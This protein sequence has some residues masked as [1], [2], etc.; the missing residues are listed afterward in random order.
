MRILGIS[1][2][3]HDAA[4]ALLEDGRLVAAGMQEAYSRV[5]HDP[6]YPKDAIEFCL[7]R[8]GCRPQDLDYVVFY[9]K[10]FSKFHRLLQTL[11]GT[12]PRSWRVFPKAMQA[13]F[14]EKLW[15]RNI[16]LERLGI[17]ASRLLFVD[18]HLSHAASSF[19]CS[20]FPDAAVLTIDGVGEWATA[21]WGL[22]SS[23]PHGSRLSLE[24]E[25]RFPHSI[26]LLYS[27]FTAFLGFEVNEGEYKVMGMAAYGSPRH[28]EKVRKLVRCFPD[29]SFELNMDYFSFHYSDHATYNR[30]FERLF[31]EPRDPSARFVT[32]RTSLYDDPTPPSPA[33]LERNQEYADIA[34]SVQKVVEDLVVAMAS[35]L[36]RR[37]GRE[38]LCMA[39]GVAFNCLANRRILR[40]TGFKELFIQ[41][42]A[43]D[44]GGALG[45]ALFAHHVLL[46]QPRR[47]AMEHAFWGE[48]FSDEQA[49]AAAAAAGLAA[50]EP[51]EEGLLERAAEALSAGKVIGFYRD[52]AEWGPRALGH[53]SILASPTKPEMKD[54]VNIKIK[55]REP[56]RPFAPSVLAERAGEYFELEQDGR[57]YPYRY[58]LLTADVRPSKRSA[59]PAVTHADGSARV[60]LVRRDSDPAYWRLI[61]RVGQST[62]SPVLLN[63]SFNLKGEPIVHTP[64]EAIASY[65]KSGLDACVLGGLW[66]EKKN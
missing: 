55:F 49:R 23:G 37:T 20:P 14:S 22:G 28:E 15:I 60:Q 52:R 34:A 47:F 21:S 17:E 53:R 63:T 32:S 35:A 56:Y 41:P 43:G 30:A 10:P 50:S 51:G 19:F 9:E 27:A 38:A 59:I 58:M 42:A 3:Y 31:G 12:A 33:E 61:E 44:A 7:R 26:G 62:G 64:A 8:A 6:H 45:A 5:K 13:W 1:C 16:L 11:V 18:H 25:I 4:A 46:R 2:F 57:P 29:G 54:I 40:E 24:E 36:Q 65:L 66:L 48:A 39:G